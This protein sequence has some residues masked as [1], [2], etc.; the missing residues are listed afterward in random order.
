MTPYPP[1]PL[2]TVQYTCILLFTQRRGGGGGGRVKPK[3]RL[4]GNA[5][6]SRSK[7]PTWL[8]VS[9]VY[10]N[11]DK[12]LPQRL[13]TGELR[14]LL[15]VLSFNGPNG[16]LFRILRLSV[17]DS[18]QLLSTSKFVPLLQWN[19]SLA[20]KKIYKQ[21]ERKGKMENLIGQDIVL[22]LG[23]VTFLHSWRVV[24]VAFRKRKPAHT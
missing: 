23:F 18:E 17:R 3:R 1:P 22:I 21:N 5:S 7:I 9:P 20:D 12:P 4:K 24:D 10:I 13:F 6:Q 8:T 16:S 2:H 14:C 15:W 19:Y 11:S